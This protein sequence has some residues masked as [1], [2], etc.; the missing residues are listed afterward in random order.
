MILCEKKRKSEKKFFCEQT[1]LP[2]KS[3]LPLP[4]PRK[5]QI[6]NIFLSKVTVY[7]ILD[8]IK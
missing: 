6:N 3:E 8:I 4:N 5:S 7:T 1:F 2:I